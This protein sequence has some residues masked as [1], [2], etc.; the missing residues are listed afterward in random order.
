M[1]PLLNEVAIAL[2]HARLYQKLQDSEMQLRQA[3]K[4]EAIGQLSAGIAHNFNN[5]LMGIMGNLHLAQLEASPTSTICSWAFMDETTR[6]RI[7]DPFFTT[8]PVD[9]GTGLGLSTVYGILKQHDGWIDCQSAPGEGTVFSAYLPTTSPLSVVS[10]DSVARDEL[11]G[12]TET[13]LVIDDEEIVRQVAV[14]ILDKLGYE[15]LAAATGLQGLSLYRQH[16]DRVD[17]VLLDLNLTD[18]PGSEIY[19]E[20]RALSP[21]LPIVLFTGYAES[22]TLPP[23]DEVPIIEKPITLERLSRSVR[24]ALAG[25]TQL[26]D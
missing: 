3:Q 12:G 22:Q 19:A 24:D 14:A 9:Q 23:G 10:Q 21:D 16:Q 17:L 25:S 7:F 13:I 11:V 1:Q 18:R 26:S 6:S 20:L 5:M 15:P 4:M 2:E 8:K